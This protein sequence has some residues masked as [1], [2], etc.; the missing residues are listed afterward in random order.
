MLHPATGALILVLDWILF[1]GTVVSAG[2]AMWP[3]SFVGFV[4]GSLGSMLIQ[5]RVAKDSLRASAVKG[6]FS[7]VAVGLPFPVAGTAIGGWILAA[8]G[9]DRLRRGRSSNAG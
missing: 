8:S 1:S 7:G 5:R 4:T 6:L 2:T 3:L 9:L